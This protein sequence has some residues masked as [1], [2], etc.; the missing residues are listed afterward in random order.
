VS[1]QD[2]NIT[3]QGDLLRRQSWSIPCA[4]QIQLHIPAVLSPKKKPPV[5]TE[6]PQSTNGYFKEEISIFLPLAI[7]LHTFQHIVRTPCH[8]RQLD[9]AITNGNLQ[10]YQFSEF[11]R[12][13]E[14]YREG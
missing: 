12:I 5:T 10:Y 11:L 8:L 14:A 2:R 7:E 9:L 4:A 1:E 13:L 3:V 6:W